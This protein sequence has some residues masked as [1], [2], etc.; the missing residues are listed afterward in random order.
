VT[1]AACQSQGAPTGRLAAQ[2]DPLL[3]SLLASRL[4]A[5][6]SLELGTQLGNGAFGVVFRG[7]FLRTGADV[8]VKV[9]DVAHVGQTLG[10]TPDET[11]RAFYWEAI[12]LA[13][14][15]HPGIVE[16]LGVC[17]DEAT[18]F[19]AIVLEFC[20]GGDLKRALRAPP[21]DVWRW[22]VQL[23]E[24]LRYLHAS[25]QVHR[26]IK[27]E[28]VLLSDGRC[29]AKFGDLGV[30]DADEEFVGDKLAGRRAR[31]QPEGRAL[32]GTR[33]AHH[34]ADGGACRHEA[35][36]ANLKEACGGSPA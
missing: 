7:R 1:P 20:G 32:G 22:A 34:T 28:N 21:A 3:P 12:N 35:T 33:R 26:D 25:G 9:L 24:A 14:C 2:P 18:S 4:V 10:F 8:A 13:L 15:D 19:R 23:A 6:D 27:G 5:R 31:L 17:V 30:A 16:L 11:V 29:V 36:R